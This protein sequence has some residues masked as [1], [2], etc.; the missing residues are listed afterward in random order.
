[1]PD[2]TR[3]LVQRHALGRA[4][5][6]DAAL[7]D[8]AQDHLMVAFKGR[9]VEEHGGVHAREGTR[10]V[11]GGGY[12]QTALRVAPRGRRSSNSWMRLSP[13]ISGRFITSAVA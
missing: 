11:D 12:S 4:D 5:A 8:I 13:V 3:A 6:Y 10:P 2:L 1:M 9:C 7:L